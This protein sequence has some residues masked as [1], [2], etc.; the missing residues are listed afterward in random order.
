MDDNLCVITESSLG[1][2]KL[3][4]EAQVVGSAQV[5]I[6]QVKIIGSA[7]VK[8]RLVVSLRPYNPEGVSLVNN[9]SLLEDS[10]GWQVNRENFVY[11]NKPPAQW[12]FSD[13]HL[14]DVYSRL[15]TEDKAKEISCK[16]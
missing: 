3:Q 4:L 15:S 8:A 5:P 14:G 7:D 11:F 2:L 16:V 13:Y 12:V 10:L 1:Q 6:C 9:I